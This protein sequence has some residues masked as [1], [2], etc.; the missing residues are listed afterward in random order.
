MTENNKSNARSPYT[1]EERDNAVK[2]AS[3]LGSVQ[4]AAKE[5]GIEAYNIRNW[6][7]SAAPTKQQAAESYRSIAHDRFRTGETREA[8]R[9]ATSTGYSDYEAVVRENERL[10]E[11]NQALRAAISVLTRDYSA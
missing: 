3:S 11:A 6:I 8:P 10:T 9:K 7:N 5:L 4:K 1:K 2:R